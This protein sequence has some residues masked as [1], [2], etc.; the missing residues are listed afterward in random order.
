V[1]DR[2]SKNVMI[3]AAVMFVLPVLGYLAYSRPWYFT[4]TSYLA[5]HL[6]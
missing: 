2:I 4:S 3:G 5:A 6:S 1:T